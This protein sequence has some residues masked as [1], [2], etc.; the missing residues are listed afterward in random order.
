MNK[1]TSA[2]S[3]QKQRKYKCSINEAH[4]LYW[5]YLFESLINGGKENSWLNLKNGAQK[6]KL[7]QKPIKVYECLQLFS[8]SNYIL[9]NYRT[10]Q[11]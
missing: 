10:A 2:H 6:S 11:T 7:L 3:K 4:Q 8:S 5:I 1:R 9:L